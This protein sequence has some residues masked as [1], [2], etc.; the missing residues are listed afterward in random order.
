MPHIFSGMS[1]A[2]GSLLTTPVREAW[3]ASNLAPG[4]GRSEFEICL[5][6]AWADYISFSVKTAE[7][8]FLPGI[9][10]FIQQALHRLYYR[11]WEK[12]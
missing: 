7:E 3:V 9:D 11:G 2:L 1:G 6:R 8:Y 12:M 5:Y 4:A 10:V